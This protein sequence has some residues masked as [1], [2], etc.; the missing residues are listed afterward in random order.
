MECRVGEAYGEAQIVRLWRDLQKRRAEVRAAE[1]A[2]RAV[3]SAENRVARQGFAGKVAAQLELERL[4]GISGLK[5]DERITQRGYYFLVLR[6]DVA[7]PTNLKEDLGKAW[8][9]F[10]IGYDF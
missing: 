1:V 6:Y 5:R 9:F 7:Q 4:G 8:K 3:N 10:S 2:Y